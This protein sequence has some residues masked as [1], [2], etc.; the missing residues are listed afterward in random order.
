MFSYKANAICMAGMTMPAGAGVAASHCWNRVRKPG[1]LINY[2][3]FWP[4]RWTFAKNRTA[5]AQT[6]YRKS[7][8]WQWASFVSGVKRGARLHLD[9]VSVRI[10]LQLWIFSSVVVKLCANLYG[11]FDQKSKFR[12][13]ASGP[14]VKEVV[15]LMEK[16][17]H[18]VTR[19]ECCIF[20]KNTSYLLTVQFQWRIHQINTHIR[21]NYSH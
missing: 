3:R 16:R 14:P 13:I 18:A 2:A 5:H 10:I 6:H 20:S 19:W 7:T 17:S 21:I 9:G 11:K 8:Q 4:H 12:Q 15:K 1:Q